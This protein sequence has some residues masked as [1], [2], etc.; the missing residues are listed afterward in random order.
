MRPTR[1]SRHCGM[2]SKRGA[3]ASSSWPLPLVCTGYWLHVLAACVGWMCWLHVLAACVGCM[4]WLHVLAACVGCMCWLHVLAKGKTPT[5]PGIWVLAPPSFLARSR[6]SA[7]LIPTLLGPHRTC[8]PCAARV[9][10][11]E[12]KP[13]CMYWYTG[14][15]TLFFTGGPNQGVP[16][17]R[18]GAPCD[19]RRCA[20]PSAVLTVQGGHRTPHHHS[21]IRLL[22]RCP[23]LGGATPPR[24]ALAFRARDGFPRVHQQTSGTNRAHTRDSGTP[25]SQYS[26]RQ[27]SRQDN[28]AEDLRDG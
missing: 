2:E 9:R 14:G 5:H 20:T 28:K 12:S 24:G 11:A 26:H 10:L 17:A 16:I 18:W 25:A 13:C 8:G 3:S 22:R 21:A 27:Q 7:R 15:P 19:G 23:A 4:C 6:E 1:R